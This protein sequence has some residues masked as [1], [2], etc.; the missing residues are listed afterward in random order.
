[1]L[2]RETLC[3]RSCAI[4]SQAVT[5]ES[6]EQ[7]LSSQS[8]MPAGMALVRAQELCQCLLEM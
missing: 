8:L 6:Q 4:L 7:W 2:S 1:M 3:Q 5:A